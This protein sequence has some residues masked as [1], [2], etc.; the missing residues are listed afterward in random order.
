[1]SRIRR[2]SLRRS[3]NSRRCRLRYQNIHH[4]NIFPRKSPPC[5]PH[6]TRTVLLERLRRACMIRSILVACSTLRSHCILLRLLRRRFHVPDT[7]ECRRNRSNLGRRGILRCQRNRIR[8]LR[9]CFLTNLWDSHANSR[10]SKILRSTRKLT[11]RRPRRNSMR[12]D[13]RCMGSRD[14]RD[15][16][17]SS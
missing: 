12:R 5:T 7:I 10:R 13:L 14:L 8:G 1:M 4:N 11:L 2:T 3:R 17:R 6:Y 15:I 16:R 9:R